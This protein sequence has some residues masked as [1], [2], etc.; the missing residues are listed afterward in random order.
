MIEKLSRNME[1]Q[2]E[3]AGMTR[4]NSFHPRYSES[5][6]AKASISTTVVPEIPRDG[7]NESASAGSVSAYDSEDIDLSL[8]LDAAA[9]AF[10]VHSGKDNDPLEADEVVNT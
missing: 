2:T 5:A 10:C 6:S 7:E 9:K 8:R 4:E 1:Q 3:R